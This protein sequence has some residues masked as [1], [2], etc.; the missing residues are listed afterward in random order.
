MKLYYDGLT[1]PTVNNFVSTSLSLSSL[2][3]NDINVTYIFE[4]VPSYTIFKNSLIEIRL[5]L[6]KFSHIDKSY[7]TA[8][9]TTNISSF[10]SYCLIQE[11]LIKILVDK[12][13]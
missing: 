10:I 13:I 11:A 12:E 5:E 4:F 2:Y 1:Q 9:C 6:N 8:I 7:P 3:S